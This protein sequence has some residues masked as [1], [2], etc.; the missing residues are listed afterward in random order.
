MMKDRVQPPAG[1]FLDV[2]SRSPTGHLDGSGSESF[3]SLLTNHHPSP[4]QYAL[5]NLTG[6]AYMNE[7]TRRLPEPLAS[8]GP[9]VTS[10]V[11]TPTYCSK[12]NKMFA[13]IEAYTKH[14]PMHEPMNM[15]IKLYPCLECGKY[16]RHNTALVIHRRTHTGEKPYG[17]K[18]CGRRFNARSSLVT[19]GKTHAGRKVYNCSQC[20]KSFARPEDLFLHQLV[21]SRERKFTCECGKGFTGEVELAAHRRAHP[22]EELFLCSGCGRDFT[23]YSKLLRHQ[24][25]H[26]QPPPLLITGDSVL[27][28][29]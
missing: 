17:C 6:G 7:P 23:Q 12:C 29:Q 21:H 1:L 25:S 8:A 26:P 22:D 5:S 3:W 27:G 19:H 24:K 11:L 13:T 14:E 15:N 9:E 16:Y 20:G 2:A 10:S 18:L 4:A 28:G